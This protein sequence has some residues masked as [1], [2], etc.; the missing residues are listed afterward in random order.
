VLNDVR[1]G[2]VSLENAHDLYGVAI[3]NNAV[4]EAATRAL[5]QAHPAPQLSWGHFDVGPARR[6]HEAKWTP[7]RYDALTRIL[8]QAPINWRFFLK[9]RL[10]AALNANP[11]KVAPGAAGVY[12]LYAAIQAEFPDLPPLQAVAA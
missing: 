11:H 2:Y 1:C 4:D 12:A 8:S 7:E 9:H 3:S 5:R 10:F 6:A